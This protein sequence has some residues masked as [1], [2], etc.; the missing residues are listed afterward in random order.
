MSAPG[1]FP[2]GNEEEPLNPQQENKLKL[3]PLTPE[4]IAKLPTVS[5][6]PA[7]DTRSQQQKAID[8]RIKN[9]AYQRWAREE[10][11]DRNVVYF[12]RDGKWTKGK[13][14]FEP[15]DN[16]STEQIV[17]KVGSDVITAVKSP[18]KFLYD[19]LGKPVAENVI[20]PVGRQIYKVPGAEFTIGT[21]GDVI[22]FLGGKSYEYIAKPFIRSSMVGLMTPLQLVENITMFAA[23]QAVV[24]DNADIQASKAS[25]WEQL[26]GIFTNTTMYYETFGRDGVESTG[27]MP[28]RVLE[29]RRAKYEEYLRPKLYDQTATVG[30]VLAGLGVKAGII[31]TGDDIH[32]L[33]SGSIDGLFNVFADP[34]NWVGVGWLRGIGV[35]PEATTAPLQ[36]RKINKLVRA[37]VVLDA[38][39]IE[40]ADEI[41]A[42]IDEASVLTDDA[43]DLLS[44][45]KGIFYSGDRHTPESVIAQ[46]EDIDSPNFSINNDNLMGPGLYVS[47]SPVLGSTY[48]K[49][50]LGHNVETEGFTRGIP[51]LDE[52]EG[53]NRLYKFSQPDDM[54][55]I[56]SELPWTD[57]PNVPWSKSNYIKEFGIDG[58]IVEDVLDELSASGWEVTPR[59]RRSALDPVF[60]GEILTDDT[61]TLYNAITN[62][63]GS[64]V[65]G[66]LQNSL[67]SLYDDF[68]AEKFFFNNLENEDILG[69]LDQHLTQAFARG[70]GDNPIEV[71]QR[72]IDR[73]VGLYDQ[74]FDIAEAKPGAPTSIVSHQYEYTAASNLMDLADV[75]K[76]RPIIEDLRQYSNELK[77]FNGR[78]KNF[79]LTGSKSEFAEIMKR[80]QELSNKLSDVVKVEAGGANWKTL[81]GARLFSDS[82]AREF[83]FFASDYREFP[84]KTI[85]KTL[86]N[87][88]TIK[89]DMY[90]LGPRV[91]KVTPPGVAQEQ[92]DARFVFNKWLASKGVDGVRMAG[93]R[94][95]GGYG[96]HNAYVILRP[97]K[98]QMKDAITGTYLPTN[99]AKGMI[100]AGKDMKLSAETMA[101]AAGFKDSAGVVDALRRSGNPNVYTQWK[102]SGFAKNLFNAI[103]SKGDA[104][105]I[106]RT[107]LKQRSPRLAG[108][109]AAAKTPEEV[110]AIFDLAVMSPDPFEHLFALPGWSGNV[111]SEAGY[112]TKQW[113]NKRS[114]IAATLPQTGT[115]PLDDFA[116]GAKYLDDALVLVRANPAVRKDLMNKYIKIVSQDDPAVIRGDLFD[117]AGEAKKAIITDR[118]KP[119]LDRLE[120]PL[121]KTT[122]EMTV[123]ERVT[124]NNRRKIVE[125]LRGY[126][127]RT[128]KW[129]D[130]GDEITRYTLDDVGRGVN[131]SWLEGNGHGP[132]YPSQQNSQGFQ[133]LPFDPDE[134]DELVALTERWALLREQA[135]TIPGMYQASKALDTA[136]RG[137]FGLFNAQTT[138]KKAVLFTGR[139]IARVVPEEM[140]RVQFSGVFSPYEFSYVSEIMSG[141]L[142]KN[143]MGQVF[144]K[145][146]E[147]QDLMAELD[148]ATALQNMINRAA[149]RGDSA[150]VAN[151]E[152][153]LAKIDVD[154]IQGRLDEIDELLE[155]E[156]PN[157]RDVMIG[158]EVGKAAD[159]ILG[160]NVPSYIKRDTQQVVTFGE[161]PR[162]WR[163]FK[164]QMIIERSVNP[165]ARSVANVLRDG[166]ITWDGSRMAGIV[167]EMLT[168]GPKSSLR[169]SF[170]QYF[171]R[172]GK[173]RPDFNWDSIEGANEYLEFVIRDINQVTSGHPTMLEAIATGKVTIGDKTIALGRRTAEGNRPTAEFL[174]LM[175]SGDEGI[176]WTKPFSEIV[177][178]DDAAAGYPRV[179]RV[180]QQQMDGAFSW[181]MTHAYG[182]A[183][184]K[185][186]RIPMW[187]ARKWNLI[188]DMVPMLSKSEAAKLRKEIVNYNLP[189][190]ITENVLDNLR[191]ARGKAT[192]KDVDFLAGYQATEETVNLLFDARKR[193]LFG[194][195]HR[196]LFAFFDAYREVGAQVIKTA[197]N[198]I[199]LHK[200]DKTIRGFENMEIGGPGDLDKDGRRE[201]FLYRDPNTG[202]MVWNVPATGQGARVLS[203]IDF[204]YKITLGSMSLATNVLPSVGPVA[205]FTYSAI[206][207][208][209]GEIWDSINKRV[210][211]FGPPSEDVRSYFTPLFLRRVGQGLAE[212]TPA[213]GFSRLI[214]GDPNQDDTYKMMNNRVFMAEIS[215]GKYDPNEESIKEAMKVSQDKANALWF[216]R[217]VTQFFAPAAPIA[218]YYYKTDKELVPL[219]VLLDGIRAVQNDV[220]AKGGN[221]QDQ[222]DAIIVSFGDDVLPYLASVSE[223]K[224]PGAEA[225]NDFYQFK[226][227]N[228]NLFDKYPDIAGYFGPNTNEFDQEIY[229]IQRRAGQLRVRS[230]EEVANEVQ[231]LWGNLRFNRVTAQIEAAYGT[232]PAASM[233]KS[234]LEAQIQKDFPSWNRG[235][236]YEQYAAKINKNMIELL[237]AADDPA[238]QAL[239]MYPTLQRYLRFREATSSAITAKNQLT[240][241]DS[242][243]S[244]KGGI[245]DREVLKSIGDRLATENPDFAPLW[246][247]VL[248]KEFRTLTPQEMRL[249]QTG[250]LP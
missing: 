222:L 45:K 59:G 140:T 70:F 44:P 125:E 142:N 208:R 230:L 173:M 78:V 116:G 197:V 176:T 48:Q 180:K 95:V 92:S 103:A 123:L 177:S 233:A 61:F 69:S 18:F 242:W 88:E 52:R 2:I 16:L 29:A 239:P 79:S 50:I 6:P 135:K 217:G 153:K 22:G 37:G 181:F 232:S 207:G 113:I 188:A 47:D 104:A 131:M 138:W 34:A 65:D 21:A 229:N 98:L 108:K 231:Q 158:P 241:V 20:E 17:G 172:Q 58:K 11:E 236:A 136:L 130:A 139:Y 225:S 167:Q 91:T 33:L 144:P 198:P 127:N 200:I 221:F 81:E 209:T 191:F 133:I 51:L 7:V 14:F 119:L 152:R 245:A 162:L 9:E 97:S 26:T 137:R 193:T 178:P 38:Q 30:R 182:R 134:L 228:Q 96:E 148:N 170:E 143:I 74:L 115:M 187:N 216:L 64:M 102:Q 42:T 76:L 157:V 210:I 174:K 129:A 86:A 19:N 121:K 10:L 43:I 8:E 227:E 156:M 249:A 237:K 67:T 218:E 220:R 93:G 106:W 62:P 35:L 163:K 66:F 57:D 101:Q 84:L 154:A 179:D 150:Q 5:S 4:Q 203:G 141:R 194:R 219:G 240:N 164:G 55:I 195:N 147:A 120:K 99:V 49:N 72:K 243:K 1:G 46:F 201:G 117:F 54:N 111:V 171:K 250:Q 90:S 110:E 25:L 224:V 3:K 36:A 32:Q 85:Q 13:A 248:S 183:S 53:A 87:G 145:V 166:A 211:P 155:S 89:V 71:T 39:T 41:L 40:K 56:D 226:N 146:G 202:E 94:L 192:L 12:K 186:A 124:M 235:L 100:E 190:Y 214:F 15:T 212:G 149:A 107:V 215:S 184:D 165:V 24:R 83:L 77:L 118:L 105:D 128:S 73:T 205:A 151:L 199:A 206:P 175:E 223:S 185:F 109:L 247:N 213:Q 168:G 189:K 244:N 68:D 132:L 28:S 234:I 80:F 82:V 204:N 169:R 63:A 27:L 159:T 160:Q 114:R 126:I 238:V 122:E 75:E 60:G 196:L 31:E 246:N 112:R 23:N 161:N